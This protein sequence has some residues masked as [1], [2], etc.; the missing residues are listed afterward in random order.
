[1]VKKG[2]PMKDQIRANLIIGRGLRKRVRELRRYVID[3]YVNGFLT[4]AQLSEA[5]DIDIVKIPINWQRSRAKMMALAV[6]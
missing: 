6:I 5:L 2:L 4:D 3:R 1:M